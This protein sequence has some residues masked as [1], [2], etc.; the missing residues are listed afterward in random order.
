MSDLGD[1]G[2]RLHIRKDKTNPRRLAYLALLLFASPP[3]WSWLAVG[4]ASVATGIALHGWAAGYIARAGYAERE[5]KL[6][7]GGP[8]RYNRNPYYLAQMIMDLRRLYSC[9]SPLVLSFLFSGHL[10]RLSALGRE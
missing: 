8:Y 10:F 6:T 2:N 5:T 7:V 3:H 4:I 1:Y 9:R